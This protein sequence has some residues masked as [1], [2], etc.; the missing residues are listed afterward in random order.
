MLGVPSCSSTFGTA[1][2]F[3]ARGCPN[4]FRHPGDMM[5]LMACSCV[6]KEGKGN[7]EG[8]VLINAQ[9]HAQERKPGKIWCGLVPAGLR[10][11]AP[12]HERDASAAT[13]IQVPEIAFAAL[14]PG[15]EIAFWGSGP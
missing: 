10:L 3:V 8:G 2:R 7:R 13:E 6:S 5:I 15:P 12:E 14:D 4:G 11:L 9:Q 1:W